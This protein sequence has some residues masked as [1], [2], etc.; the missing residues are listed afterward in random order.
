MAS[1]QEE[2]TKWEAN[3]IFQTPDEVDWRHTAC[4]PQ[5]LAVDVAKDMSNM[6]S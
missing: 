1:S 4:F 6:S 2:F 5:M 3:L